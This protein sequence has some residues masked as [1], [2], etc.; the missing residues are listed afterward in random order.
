MRAGDLQNLALATVDEL[1]RLET[2]RY[3][4]LMNGF[5]GLSQQFHLRHTRGEL[6]C[7]EMRAMIERHFPNFHG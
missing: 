4:R 7:F 1:D 3:F 5:L 6:A 2:S